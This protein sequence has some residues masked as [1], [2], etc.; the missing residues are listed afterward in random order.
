[1]VIF[2][3]VLEELK[4]MYFPPITMPINH[5]TLDKCWSIIYLI[6]P[7]YF[8]QNNKSQMNHPQSHNPFIIPW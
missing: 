2:L 8:E 7:Y 1:M 5:T 3:Y 4:A 6:M